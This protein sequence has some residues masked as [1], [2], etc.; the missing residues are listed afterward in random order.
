MAPSIFPVICSGALVVVHEGYPMG[1]PFKYE[2]LA[3][4]PT[5]LSKADIL[6]LFSSCTIGAP[7]IGRARATSFGFDR[8]SKMTA[9]AAAILHAMTGGD[10]TRGGSAC[11]ECRPVPYLSIV[12][13]CKL[14][15]QGLYR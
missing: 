10:T 3:H 2:L 1:N 13:G 14:T 5:T 7:S 9:P 8:E 4:G 12:F 15:T 6:H 11:T